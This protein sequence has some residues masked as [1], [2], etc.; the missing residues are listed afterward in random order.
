MS[1]NDPAPAST[2]DYRFR[3]VGYESDELLVTAF[4]GGEALSELF[5]FRV[6]LC[7]SDHTIEPATMLGLAAWLEIEGEWG[8]R[9]VRGI[10]QRFERVRDGVSRAYY[11]AHIVPPHWLLTKRIQSRALNA[12][13]CD[14]MD[15]VGVVSKVL[16]DAGF[17]PDDLKVLT[18]R[19]YEPREFVAQYRESDWD[20]ISRLLED[21]GVYYYFEHSVERC[22]LV[23]VDS[24]ELHLPYVEADSTVPFREPT[25][26]VE[27]C[28]FVYE[29]R[30]CDEVQ[31]G[32]VSLDD[33]NFREPG[34]ELRLSARGA[35]FSTLQ[36][37]D[38]P[39][40][41][42][43]DSRGRRLA[44][45]RLQEQQS[46]AA[47]LAMSATARELLPGTR[48]TLTEHPHEAFNGD[49][50]ITA[51]QHRATQSQI[52][53]EEGA[54]DVGVR[55]GCDLRVIP[56][57]VQFR[58]PRC[59]PRPTVQGTQ[60]AIVVGPASEEIHTD[61]YG[62]VEV[63]FHWDREAQYDVGASC[64]I[65]VSQGLAGG[66]YGM[67]FLPRVGQE[68]VVDFLEGDP[69]QPI[70]VGRVYNRDHMPPYKL[71]DQRSISTIRTCSS[72]GG[73][74]AN[75]IRFDD[76]KGK[77]QLALFAQD[78]MHMRSRGNRYVTVGGELHRIVVKDSFEQFKEK[79]HTRIGLDRIDEIGGN[80]DHYVD[81]DSHEAVTGQKVLFV[82]G[83]FS[84]TNSDGVVIDSD[85]AITLRVKGNFIRIDASGI[86]LVGTAVNIN[87]G[88][89]A[90]VA[91]ET[92][93]IESQ[94]PQQA[95]TTESG[96][97]FRYSAKP[98]TL[99]G[100]P[101]Q[102]FTEPS[103]NEQQSDPPSWIEIEL[104]DDAGNPCDGEAYLVVEP[105]G[106]EHRGSLDAR[107]LARVAVKKPG[108]CRITF[109]ELDGEAWDRAAGAA[110][111]VAAGA[112]M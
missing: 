97:N 111:G 22:K 53:E 5:R 106:A 1:P 101:P 28:A 44:E 100:T 6:S 30:R 70:I 29:A 93:P 35:R 33:F 105:D 9:I 72:P 86:S 75:E 68:V 54:G 13:R 112:S 11:E 65:R 24:K 98:V 83:K 78:S 59:T 81:K 55:Y 48:F 91:Q 8:T 94:L 23:L 43:D 60:T 64:W 12:K 40:D 79:R 66:Q 73:G 104:I 69:D 57:S 18:A 15:V 107:G 47:V 17:A 49:Y 45:T 61:A 25:G 85:T 103:E 87:S 10:I 56:A 90:D 58:P 38:F 32:A 52:G 21:E 71:P 42:A 84:I 80:H 96:R 7:S 39:G 109:P 16:Q 34:R 19:T 82:G 27:E 37:T 4:E 3:A 88:G 26:L 95:A 2:A 31:I 36:F 62:R 51:I 77:E 20:F 50:L 46:N 67:M 102:T 74:G 99:E 92:M 41:F 110:G 63:R 76:A 14:R 108:D 89:S